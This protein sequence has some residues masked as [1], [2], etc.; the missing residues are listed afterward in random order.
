MLS[1]SSVAWLKCA[2]MATGEDTVP[3][4]S[5]QIEDPQEGGLQ[6]QPNDGPFGRGHS[7]WLVIG[8]LP[9]HSRCPHG[10]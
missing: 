5:T 1:S 7:G 3:T 8:G 6:T 9:S 10:A 2:K 4:R